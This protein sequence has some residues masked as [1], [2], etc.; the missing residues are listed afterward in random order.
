VAEWDP[1]KERLT[2]RR[3]GITFE[4]ASSV[5]DDP[6][7]VDLED[8]GHS[9]AEERWR[10]IGLSDRGRLLVVTWTWRSGRVRVI[11]AWRATKREA[12]VYTRW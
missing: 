10:S 7:R 11:T 1:N 9:G 5:L 12:D 6:R 4:E 8:V 3:R 2:L